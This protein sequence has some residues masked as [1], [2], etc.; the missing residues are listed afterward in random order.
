MVASLRGE[1]ATGYAGGQR[2]AGSL[3]Q[4]LQ[5]RRRER[6]EGRVVTAPVGDE[7]LLT[8][9]VSAQSSTSGSGLTADGMPQAG[10][11]QVL[12]PET[13]ELGSI[14]PVVRVEQPRRNS[15]GKVVARDLKGFPQISHHS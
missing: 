3:L 13:S 12:S 5:S 14:P 6:Q 15:S 2:R 11:P 1:R 7:S 10:S 9:G 8:S 4:Q